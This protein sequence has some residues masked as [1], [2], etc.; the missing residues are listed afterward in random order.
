MQDLYAFGFRNDLSRVAGYS[1]R[2]VDSS[3]DESFDSAAPDTSSDPVGRAKP[4]PLAEEQYHD[5][6]LTTQ[7]RASLGRLA[8]YEVGMGASEASARAIVQR[9]CVHD[10]NT[11]VQLIEQVS[12]LWL[13][14]YLMKLL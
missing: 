13:L 8:L 11:S 14:D 7:C 9:V 3:F 10:R 12:C 4:P 2:G 1:G 6:R 5:L